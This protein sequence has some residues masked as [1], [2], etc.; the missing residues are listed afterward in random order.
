MNLHMSK[1]G[2]SSYMVF[3]CPVRTSTHHISYADTDQKPYSALVQ[4]KYNNQT[5]WKKKQHVNKYLQITW[6][7]F[8]ELLPVQATSL[9]RCLATCIAH[10]WSAMLHASETW[11]LT[12]LNL[13]RL[14]QNDSSIIRQI[15]NVKPQD[16]VTIRSNELRVQLGIEDLDLM[17]KERSSQDA[18]PG[19]YRLIESVGLGDPRWHGS[20]WQR[21]RREWKLLAIDLHDRHT[22]AILCEICHACSKP[23]TW[24]GAHWCRCRPCTCTVHYAQINQTNKPAR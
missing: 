14:Q 1:L 5:C 18:I 22:L 4:D 6:K 8:K 20:S 19:T 16:T 12:K 24:K 10:I 13:Q 15:C 7:K 11:L 2:N 21:D 23:A 17:R 3:C 9:S